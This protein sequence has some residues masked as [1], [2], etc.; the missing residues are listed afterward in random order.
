VPENAVEIQCEK[1]TFL[2]RSSRKRVAV[3]SILPCPLP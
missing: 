3:V 1:E 2:T